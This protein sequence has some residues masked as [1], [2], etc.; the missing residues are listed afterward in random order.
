MDDS[1]SNQEKLEIS[2]FALLTLGCGEIV[3][4]LSEG[5]IEDKFGKRM[6]LLYV[7]LLTAVAF[8]LLFIYNESHTYSVL[9]FF[10]TFFWG[11]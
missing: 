9:T 4:A 8:V 5:K 10:M 11:F 6:G 1:Y 3:G 7:M 2:F